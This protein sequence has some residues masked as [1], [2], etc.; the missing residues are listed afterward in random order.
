M[1]APGWGDS[2]VS[3]CVFSVQMFPLS[4]PNDLDI[5]SCRFPVVNLPRGTPG[6]CTAWLRLRPT[7]TSQNWHKLSFLKT[8]NS[9]SFQQSLIE[10]FSFGS[11]KVMTGRVWILTI[12]PLLTD[13]ADCFSSFLPS[14]CITSSQ[15]WFWHF[16]NIFEFHFWRCDEWDEF[17]HIWFCRRQCKY[18][19][20]SPCPA[21]IIS[22]SQS[23]SHLCGESPFDW[24]LSWFAAELEWD[25]CWRHRCVVRA[26]GPHTCPPCPTG[27]Q[28]WTLGRCQN[29]IMAIIG[30]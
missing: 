5:K 23:H 6:T 8:S 22:L 20:G 25:L 15:V 2:S 10:M 19:R 9:L 16:V 18:L 30:H 21:P 28:S 29:G 3:S 12:I 11:W 7:P 1:T 4:L 27:H 13:G 17:D 26:P 24:T 14:V